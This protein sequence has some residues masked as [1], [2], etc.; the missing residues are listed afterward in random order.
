MRL[1]EGSAA[2]LGMHLLVCAMRLYLEMAS[3]ES[4]HVSR[5]DS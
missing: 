1:G 2:I 5:S 3:F 4:A